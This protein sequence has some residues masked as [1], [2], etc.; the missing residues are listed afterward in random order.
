ME[1]EGKLGQDG[2]CSLVSVV[3]SGEV[4]EGGAG[5]GAAAAAC[6]PDAAAAALALVLMRGHRPIRFPRAGRSR[7]GGTGVGAT[8]GQMPPGRGQEGGVAKRGCLAM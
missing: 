6:V 7:P 4:L 8:E 2:V 1:E 3:S 5:A